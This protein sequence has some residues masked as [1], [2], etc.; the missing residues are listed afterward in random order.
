MNPNVN[1][2]DRGDEKKQDV[3]NKEYATFAKRYLVHFQLPFTIVTLPMICN[4]ITT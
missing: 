4:I 2:N 1:E 3:E